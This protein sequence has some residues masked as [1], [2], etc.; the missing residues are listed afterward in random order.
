MDRAG[1]DIPRVAAMLRE[2]LGARPIEIQLPIGGG[3]QFRGV[4]D[5]ISGQARVWDEASLG[6]RSEVIAVPAELQGAAGEAREAMLEGLAEADEAFC[7]AYLAGE[8]LGAEEIRAALRRATLALKTV[9]VLCGS[10][11]RNKGVQLLLDAVVHYLPSPADQPPALG[12]GLAGETLEPRRVGDDAPFVALAFKVM[13]DPYVGQLTFLRVY[14]GTL[15]AGSYVL[16]PKSGMKERI[17]RILEMHANERHEVETVFT[18]DIVAAVGLK[19]TVTGDTLCDPGA[20]MVLETMEFPEPVIS[21]TVEPRTQ[22]DQERLAVSL[23]KIAAEDPSFRVRV[24]ADTGQTLIS[25]MGELHLEIIVDRLMREFKVAAN[26]GKPTVAYRE[27][28]TASAQAEGRLERQSGG[29][30]QYGHVVLRVE[31][32]PGAETLVFHNAVVGGAI[33]KEYIPAVQR[34]LEEALDR[35]VLAGYPVIGLKAT[36]LDGSFHP[37]DSSEMAFKMAASLGLQ[38]AVRQAGPQLLEPVMEVEV[39]TPEAFLG[40]VIAD[41]EARRGKVAAMEPRVGARVVHVEVPLASMFGYATALRSRTQGRATYSMQFGAYRP[42]PAAVS[43]PSA[44]R[45]R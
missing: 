14:A 10:A 30:G 42:V 8:P 31:P 11:F 16:N 43:D 41:L 19:N 35:G 21:V 32:C 36:L 2:R 25:G 9:P 4:V 20:P 23:A 12:R 24:D 26:V 37:V 7:E 39:V 33:P 45:L 34:G 17:G 5:L 3:E 1:A 13:T 27:T 18:G 38:V 28:I 44:A 6:A 29:R 15:Q 40:E 22:A